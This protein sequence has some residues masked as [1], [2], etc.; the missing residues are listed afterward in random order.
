MR[1]CISCFISPIWIY[2]SREHIVKD[3]D[4][5][6]K[7]QM[8]Q[9][10]RTNTIEY[11]W[12]ISLL[13]VSV[14]QKQKSKPRAYGCGFWIIQ[15]CLDLLWLPKL[16]LSKYQYLIFFYPEYFFAIKS[17][18]LISGKGQIRMKISY[19]TND[20]FNH[21]SALNTYGFFPCRVFLVYF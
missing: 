16:F 18:T 5:P 4:E 20:F 2:S 10:W 7:G 3:N 21:I 1:L 12:G 17:S 6:K 9:R 13:D 8:K 14:D 15:L 19:I 11:W